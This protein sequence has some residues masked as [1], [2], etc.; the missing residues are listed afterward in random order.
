MFHIHIV[1]HSNRG[2]YREELEQ[3]YQLRHEIY[4]DERGWYDLARPDGREIDAFD[5]EDAVY[6]LGIRP[7][8][9]VVAGSRLVPSVK[10]HL[11]S[12]VFPQLALQGVPRDKNTF[13][14]TR[15]FV[16]PEMRQPG[17]PCLAAG[18]VYCGIIEFCLQRGIG[19]ISIVCETYWIERLAKLGWNPRPLGQPI[20]HRGET[21][22]GLL[23]DIDEAALDSTR[24]AYDITH[25]VLWTQRHEASNRSVDLHNTIKEST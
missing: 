19:Q 1:D 17:R 24:A 25:S 9:G 6:L 16:V 3:H 5:T 21:I 13:E 18:I 20:E 11:M 7:G 15:I 10:P 23:V 14:W 12:D 22:V 4:V 8:K 2:I